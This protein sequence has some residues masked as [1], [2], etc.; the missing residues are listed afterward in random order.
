MIFL[1]HTHADKP[2]VEPVALQ[3][4]SIFGQDE[5]FYDSWSIRPGDGIIDRM[6]HGMTSPEFVFFFVSAKS[7]AS[8]MAK[9]EWQNALYQA[10]KGKT[11]LIPV[12]VDG[13]PM[14]AILSQ[15][16]YIDMFA[17]GIDAAIRQIVSL[18]QGNASFTPAHEAFSNLTWT[19]DGD[20]SSQLAVTI[21]ASHLLEPNPSFAFLVANR[22]E[23]VHCWIRGAPAVRSGPN[24]NTTLPDGR[25][26]GIILCAP[27]SG[28]LTPQIPIAF[29]LAPKPGA[30]PVAL[31]EV[32]HQAA[33]REYKTIPR[34][35]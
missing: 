26:A 21:K 22:I 23:E 28:A 31:I 7:L 12:R 1:S 17:N 19:V 15:T 20:P 16:V 2:V 13:A 11:R 18:V 6:N 29:T 34:A 9:L 8:E 3:L 32:M 25:Q 27:F 24:E 35:T 5:V 10:T 33:E 4:A 30:T 14:P